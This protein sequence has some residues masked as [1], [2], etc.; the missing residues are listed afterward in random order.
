MKD[1][2]LNDYD[3]RRLKLYIRFNRLGRTNIDVT[4]ES[5]VIDVGINYVGNKIYGDVDF[6]SVGNKV[7]KYNACTRWCWCSYRYRHI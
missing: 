2:V 6:H 7:K 3:Y 4:E 5:T 1:I